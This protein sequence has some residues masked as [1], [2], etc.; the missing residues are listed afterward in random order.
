MQNKPYGCSFCTPIMCLAWWTEF[1]SP[2]CLKWMHSGKDA[3]TLKDH[4]TASLLQMTQSG[5]CKLITINIIIVIFSNKTTI[6]NISDIVQPFLCKEAQSF[7]LWVDTCC[8]KTYINMFYINMCWYKTH[9]DI[10]ISPVLY[11]HV[12]I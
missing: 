12:L 8:Y 9:V 7:W 11:Q 3:Q 10:Q 2:G 6:K 5:N 4:L 1:H